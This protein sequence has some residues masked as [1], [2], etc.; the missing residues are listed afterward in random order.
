MF[1]PVQMRGALRVGESDVST[2]VFGVFFMSSSMEGRLQRALRNIIATDGL[3]STPLLT[4]VDHSGL[5]V[6]FKLVVGNALL[7]PS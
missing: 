6:V 3:V 4:K 7:I 5:V 2:Y 1:L